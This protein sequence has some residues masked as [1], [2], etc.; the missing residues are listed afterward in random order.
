MVDFLY[1]FSI[2]KY[3]RISSIINGDIQQFQF[4]VPPKKNDNL[5]GEKIS[6]K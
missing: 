3:R 2:Y 5:A 6:K 4:T 1:F